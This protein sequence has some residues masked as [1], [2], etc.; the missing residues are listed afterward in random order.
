MKIICTKEEFAA[1]LEVCGDREK[2]GT[3]K[4]CPLYSI[5]G[6]EK[7][8]IKSCEI[9]GSDYPHGGTTAQPSIFDI[10]CHDH[11]VKEMLLRQC[12]SDQ[13]EDNCKCCVLRGFCGGGTDEANGGNPADIEEFLKVWGERD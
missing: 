2:G 3:C 8:I 5:C 10:V 1:M 13:Y 4:A 11:E 6:G 12:I 9:G 7:G